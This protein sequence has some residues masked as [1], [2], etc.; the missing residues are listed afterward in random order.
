MVSVYVAGIVELQEIDAVPLPPKD[1]WLIEPQLSPEGTVAV[2][3]VVLV[4]PWIRATV[5]VEV[6]DEPTLTADGD[7]APSMKSGGIP[8]VNEAVV[9]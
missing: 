3:V 6:A 9:V 7:E 8:N 1:V 2:K 5:M 4:S